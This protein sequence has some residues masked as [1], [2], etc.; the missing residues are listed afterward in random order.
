M[1]SFDILNLKGTKDNEA[2]EGNPIP[3]AA[4]VSAP[5]VQEVSQEVSAGAE[6]LGKEVQV[7]EVDELASDDNGEFYRFDYALLNIISPV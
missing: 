3:V 4:S 5:D 6:A 2:P 1:V 7:E